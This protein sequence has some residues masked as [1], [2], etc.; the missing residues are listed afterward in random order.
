MGRGWTVVI[1]MGSD[2]EWFEQ[3][4]D[5]LCLWTEWKTANSS[6][7]DNGWGEIFFSVVYKS[8]LDCEL[9]QLFCNHVLLYHS[10]IWIKR[11][12][13]LWNLR[14]ICINWSSEDLMICKNTICKNKHKIGKLQFLQLFLLYTTQNVIRLQWWMQLKPKRCI[15]FSSSFNVKILP[16][17]GFSI[18]ICCFLHFP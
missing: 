17:Q 7:K 16:I 9:H 10:V 8:K 18:R 14:Y 15:I 13:S 11:K 5:H 2:E 12:N 6:L 4:M 3:E 1:L